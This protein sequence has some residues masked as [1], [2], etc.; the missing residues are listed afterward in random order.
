[1]TDGQNRLLKVTGSPAARCAPATRDRKFI[2]AK[3]IL[4][5]AIIIIIILHVCAA[6]RTLNC[7]SV[8]GPSHPRD[9]IATSRDS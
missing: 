7:L 6:V 4:T 1:M 2:Y 8:R 5:K 9:G 3:S